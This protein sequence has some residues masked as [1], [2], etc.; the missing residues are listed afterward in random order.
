MPAPPELRKLA[1]NKNSGETILHKATKPG[2]EVSLKIAV[3]CM[4]VY[5]FQHCVYVRVC[6]RLHCVYI[7]VFVCIHVCV[8]AWMNGCPDVCLLA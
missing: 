4:R 6:L 7:Y 3:F 2:Y 8:Y 1:V 5:V